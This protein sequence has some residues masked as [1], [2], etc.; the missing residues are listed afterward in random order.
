MYEMCDTLSRNRAYI[1]KDF[2][3]EKTLFADILSNTHAAKLLG[4]FDESRFIELLRVCRFHGAAADRP[5]SP[6]GSRGCTARRCV[7]RIDTGKRPEF[8]YGFRATER[9]SAFGS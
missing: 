6:A 3:T 7:E 8:P 2:S 9:A 4:A 1:E 5:A